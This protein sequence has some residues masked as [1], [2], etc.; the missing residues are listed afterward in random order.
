MFLLRK[1][2]LALLNKTLSTFLLLYALIILLFYTNL[3]LN[4][5][6]GESEVTTGYDFHLGTF[7]VGPA[8]NNDISNTSTLVYVINIGLGF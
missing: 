2:I 5:S 8:I 7:S 6:P 1:S 4:K 3:S